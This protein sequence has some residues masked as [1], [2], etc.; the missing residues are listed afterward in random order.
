VDLRRRT[1]HLDG[2]TRLFEQVFRLDDFTGVF[3]HQKAPVF[4][5]DRR[6]FHFIRVA[7]EKIE[8]S[9]AIPW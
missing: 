2:P 3:E 6:R 1:H 9:H 5:T 8:K 4:L 7:S